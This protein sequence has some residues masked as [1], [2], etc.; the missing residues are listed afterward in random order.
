MPGGLADVHHLDDPRGQRERGAAGDRRRGAAPC[1]GDRRGIPL[2]RG[3]TAPRRKAGGGVPPGGVG[4]H[5][6]LLQE[7]DGRRQPLPLR[8]RR[9]RRRRLGLRPEGGRRP[10]PPSAHHDDADDDDGMVMV[11]TVMQDHLGRRHSSPPLGPPAWGSPARPHHPRA[12]RRPPRVHTSVYGA[13]MLGHDLAEY[14]TQ[15][16][17]SYSIRVG[18]PMYT[19]A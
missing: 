15:T 12:G 18:Y 14:S 17:T 7:H 3:C 19:H 6:G 10:S 16:C 9:H 4:G 2:I 5:D 11:V 1:E 13:V 8:R